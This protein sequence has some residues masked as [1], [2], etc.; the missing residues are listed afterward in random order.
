MPIS[1]NILFFSALS[2]WSSSGSF[3]RM[4]I[5]VRQAS[6]ACPPR[7]EHC[8]LHKADHR[9]LMREAHGLQTI[10]HIRSSNSARLVTCLCTVWFDNKSAIVE[11]LCGSPVFATESLFES[12]TDSRFKYLLIYFVKS[13]VLSS[14]ST[15]LPEVFGTVEQPPWLF[16]WIRIIDSSSEGWCAWC[17][18]TLDNVC[19]PNCKAVRCVWAKSWCI[20][21]TWERSRPGLVSDK[22]AADER[23]TR[24]VEAKL[25]MGRDMALIWKQ[26]KHIPVRS[27][28]IMMTS[29]NGNIFRATGHL[30]GDFTGPG[31]FPTQR[32]VMRSF[33]V[34]FDLS[35]NKRLSKQSWGWWFETPSCSLWRHRNVVSE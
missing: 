20:W 12:W 11:F 24:R 3:A 26:Q 27:E 15:F 13:I 10:P 21:S 17:V 4:V 1:L 2:I 23:R 18:K 25:Y 33:G 6:S 22:T 8:T 35:Q 30:C 9:M 7:R 32:P 14:V 31:E 29:S 19:F 5:S 34:Y 16:V 28:N